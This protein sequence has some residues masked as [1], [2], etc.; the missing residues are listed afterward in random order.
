MFFPLLEMQ[1]KLSYFN[2]AYYPLL[3]YWTFTCCF[4][5]CFYFKR[6]NYLRH[7]WLGLLRFTELQCSKLP[8][9]H[10]PDM[11]KRFYVCV[12]SQ[13]SQFLNTDIK[14]ASLNYVSSMS[15]CFILPMT[16]SFRPIKI[17]KGAIRSWRISSTHQIAL[18]RWSTTTNSVRVLE[19]IPT[20]IMTVNLPTLVTYRLACCNGKQ[21]FS[22][23]P[24]DSLRTNYWSYFI[25]ISIQEFAPLAYNLIHVFTGKS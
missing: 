11:F 15:S 13:P 2:N 18:R 25:L 3:L 4:A 8:L 19:H 23:G 22:V 9:K 24:V 5:V 17:I 14:Q 6:R 21:T 20:H 10:V 1:L 12:T 16:K 7:S